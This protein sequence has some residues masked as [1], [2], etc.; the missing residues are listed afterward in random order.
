M[1][2]H[3]TCC[4]TKCTL[5]KC[6]VMTQLNHQTLSNWRRNTPRGL[7]KGPQA[8]SRSIVS[9]CW[10]TLDFGTWEEWRLMTDVSQTLFSRRIIISS[11]RNDRRIL[12]TSD[13]WVLIYYLLLE[14]N[15][16]VSGKCRESL[17]WDHLRVLISLSFLYYLRQGGLCFLRKTRGTTDFI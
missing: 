8:M 2:E 6:G 13:W 10:A 17:L 16:I 12:L 3:T 14:L 4:N 15:K 1:N 5:H 11:G 9:C 7:L